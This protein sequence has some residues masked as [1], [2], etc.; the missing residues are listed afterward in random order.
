MKRKQIN[1]I[2][3]NKYMDRKQLETAQKELDKT[4]FVCPNCGE[5]ELW[6]IHRKYSCQTEFEKQAEVDYQANN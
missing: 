4:E 1:I 5:K 6:G 3:N 2:T